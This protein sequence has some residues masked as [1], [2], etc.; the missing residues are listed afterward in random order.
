[1]YDI[2]CIDS[3]GHDLCLAG[4][5]V[6]CNVV[7]H[8]PKMWK[9]AGPNRNEKRRILLRH[10]DGNVCM[11]CGRPFGPELLPTIDHVKPRALGGGDQL[12]N[13]VLACRNCNGKKA[14]KPPEDVPLFAFVPA[15]VAGA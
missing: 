15:A 13:L 6:R 2:P 11:Y 8:K 12:E 7:I 5:C 10:R 14:D 4:W 9:R 3:S 1:M